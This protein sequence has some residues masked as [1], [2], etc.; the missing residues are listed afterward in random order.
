MFRGGGGGG[1]AEGGSRSELVAVVVE[2][3]EIYRENCG[4][5][6][7][8]YSQSMRSTTFQLSGARSN[9]SQKR[10]MINF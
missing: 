5:L 9:Q 4:V 10:D 1:G 8:D 3:F 7:V 2:G 6:V